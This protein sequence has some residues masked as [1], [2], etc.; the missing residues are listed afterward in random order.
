MDFMTIINTVRE[1][2]PVPVIVAVIAVIML[3]YGSSLFF[4]TLEEYLKEQE[5]M[6]ICDIDTRELTKIIREEGVMKAKIL[7]EEPKNES[8][9]FEIEDKVSDVSC[10]EIISLETND[11]EKTAAILDLG[12]LFQH[13]HLHSTFYL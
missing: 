9:D 12:M 4:T 11:A 6:G 8:F 1:Y 3:V 5:V 10:E 7:L 13:L 2:I